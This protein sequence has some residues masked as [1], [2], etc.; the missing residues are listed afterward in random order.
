MIK[1]SS[2]ALTT[3]ALIRRN[4]PLLKGWVTL[5]LNIRLK[6]YVYRQHIHRWIGEW[7]YSNTAAGSF[8][9]Q[10]NFVADFI[11][12]NLNFIHTNDKF[13]FW[14]TLWGELGVTYALQLYSLES[15]WSTSI[16]YKWTFYD[17]S[18]G[19]DVISR[20]WSKSAVF[21]GGGS[22]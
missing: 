7:F 11:Q 1:H 9:T 17:N 3:N 16:R 15:A 2:L 8:H 4:P 18:Y 6:D 22:L 14:A 5:G 20:Y 13:A 12:L 21:K 19:W 10:K